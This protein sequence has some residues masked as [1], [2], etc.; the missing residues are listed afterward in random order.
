M[1]NTLQMNDGWV[2]VRIGTTAVCWF[3]STQNCWLLVLRSQRQILVSGE[4]W[5][6]QREPDCSMSIHLRVPCTFQDGYQ[7]AERLLHPR[8]TERHYECYQQGVRQKQDRD[9]GVLA[10][11]GASLMWQTAPRWCKIQQSPQQTT[12]HAIMLAVFPDETAQYLCK[13]DDTSSVWRSFSIFKAVEISVYSGVYLCMLD[14]AA[15]VL[16]CSRVHCSTLIHVN[17]FCDPICS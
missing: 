10:F 15:L 12:Q 4:W 16:Q 2:A 5:Q 6:Y 11:H 1:S 8:R 14:A 17:H 13:R 9:V 3:G 7:S